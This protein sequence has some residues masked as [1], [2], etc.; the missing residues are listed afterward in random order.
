MKE[1]LKAA[2][3]AVA[4]DDFAEGRWLH[5]LSY[6]EFVA[7]RKIAKTVGAAH[8]TVAVLRHLATDMGHA[9]TFKTLASKK[10]GGEPS[11][12]VG[13]SAA[14]VYLHKLD[15]EL[16]AWAAELVG[17]KHLILTY[18]LVSTMVQRRAIELYSTY[19]NATGDEEVRAALREIIEE[20]RDQYERT[21]ENCRAL[22]SEY[23]I[24]DLATPQTVESIYFADF[25]SE[26]E[27]ELGMSNSTAP[28][29]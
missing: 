25:W 18:L 9:T 3:R 16:D 19:Q 1:R 2:L 5:T 29:A 8:P 28:N 4:A 7:A 22:L 6:L 23:G 10:C 17:E 13:L 27:G 14:G 24:K 26:V 15:R 11:E 20:E 12:Y 21:E